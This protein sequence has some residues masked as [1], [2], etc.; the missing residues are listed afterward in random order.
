MNLQINLIYPWEQ[1]S[2][3]PINTKSVVRMASIIVPLILVVIVGFGVLSSMMLK[4]NLK[5][6]EAV[7][8]QYEPRQNEITELRV[9][10]DTLKSVLAEL[11][12]Y[13][14]ARLDWSSYLN[15]IVELA[16]ESMQ[17]TSID[18]QSNQAQDEEDEKV[19][20]QK[21]SLKI[22]GDTYGQ[23]ANADLEKFKNQVKDA[24]PF[25]G[26]VSE[27]DITQY[28]EVSPTNIRFTIEVDFESLKF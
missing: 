23:A 14:G 12:R 15:A 7:W 21:Y 4:N 18:M 11:E 6:S 22:M 3:S 8:A 2:A 24:E 25:K 17:I 9:R 20:L 1:R 16:P 5:D 26:A 19:P 10:I 27:S 13:E 28:R